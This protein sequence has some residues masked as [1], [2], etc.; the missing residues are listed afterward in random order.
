MQSNRILDIWRF[1]SRSSLWP[2]LKTDN[3]D[4]LLKITARKSRHVFAIEQHD[5]PTTFRVVAPPYSENSEINR[6]DVASRAV[7]SDPSGRDLMRSTRYRPAACRSACV[8]GS[9]GCG[10]RTVRSRTRPGRSGSRQS[11]RRGRGPRRRSW[12]RRRDRALDKSAGKRMSRRRGRYLSPRPH[13]PF[14][15]CISP[16]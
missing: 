9:G 6:E 10:G 1:F 3:L 12:S 16:G 14:R 4:A 11:P 7:S 2:V 8:R 15:T 13:A 5:A